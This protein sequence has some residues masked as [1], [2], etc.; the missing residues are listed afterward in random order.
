[1]SFKRLVSYHA[2]NTLDAVEKIKDQMLLM[3][4][5]IHDDQSGEASPYY[6][7]KSYG[8]DIIF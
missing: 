3:G 1:M 6:I 4:W 7:L 8:E 2:T 5:T